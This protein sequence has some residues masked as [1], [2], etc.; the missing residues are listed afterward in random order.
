MILLPITTT[1]TNYSFTY[2]TKKHLKKN[3]NNYLIS[4]TDNKLNEFFNIKPNNC[5]VICNFFFLTN[6]VSL[7]IKKEN[8]YN[9]TNFFFY[10]DD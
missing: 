8:N 6:V 2:S 10:K 5:C 1:A 7:Y 3:K 4:K 9:S